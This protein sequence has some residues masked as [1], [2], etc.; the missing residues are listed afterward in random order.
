VFCSGN[1]WRWLM[2]DNPVCVC[3]C[4]CVCT[5]C[6]A[7]EWIRIPLCVVC[8]HLCIS[9]LCVFI[10]VEFVCMYTY[11]H[12]WTYV[13][14]HTTRDIWNT[15]IHTYS[16]THTHTHTHT[17]TQGYLAS[18]SGS[19]FDQPDQLARYIHI[20][21]HTHWQGRYI[22][23]HT[24]T[25]KADVNTKTHTVYLT[26]QIHWQGTHFR[27]GENVLSTVTLYCK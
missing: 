24:H 4:V 27:G 26:N 25:G 21:T 12:L 7:A 20:H 18:F 22:F 10:Y 8:V 23:T 1:G 17:N 9:V 19:A 13:C 14:T 5:Y 6:C 15:Y 3:V 2:P 16:H 11:I